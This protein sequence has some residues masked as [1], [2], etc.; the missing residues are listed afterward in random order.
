MKKILGT[1]LAIVGITGISAFLTGRPATSNS[2]GSGSTNIDSTS[3]TQSTP[4][5]TAPVAYRDGTYTGDAID[6]DYGMVQVQAV[7][8]GGKI[9]NIK[10]LQTP[11]AERHSVE[12]SNFAD[13][14]LISEA[15]TA[16]S[17]NVDAIS[18]ASST[19]EGFRQSLGGA[20]QKAAS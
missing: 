4:A 8:S 3:N 6:V 12:V 7:I 18:G 17:A 10:F 1:L 11:T 2:S 19:S 15:L 13:P 14:Q 16:Q 20:L 9:T 5:N